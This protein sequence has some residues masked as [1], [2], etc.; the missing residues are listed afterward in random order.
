LSLSA[1]RPLLALEHLA[2]SRLLNPDRILGGILHPGGQQRNR[3]NV[4]LG[5]VDRAA[6][7]KV[8]GGAEVLRRSDALR[9]K[10]QN[11]TAGNVAAIQSAAQA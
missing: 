5:L 9:E 3:Y 2:T 11:L 4:Q 8:S 1:P 6:A 10:V 7:L